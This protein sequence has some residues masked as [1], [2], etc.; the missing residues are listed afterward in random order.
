MDHGFGSVWEG[1]AVAGEAAVLHEPAEGAFD[2]PAPWLDGEPPGCGVALDDFEVDAAGGGV[3]DGFVL[4]AVVG[5]GFGDG[6]VV[7]GEVVEEVR[8]AGGVVDAGRG[9]LVLQRCLP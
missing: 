4:V 5:P 1:F 2:D 9:D 3:L 6:G 7:G 8:A